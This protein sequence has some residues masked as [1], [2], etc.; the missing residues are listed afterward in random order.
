MWVQFSYLKELQRIIIV[1]NKILKL[2][3]IIYFIMALPLALS[4]C[5]ALS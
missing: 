2:T 4:I 5:S 1:S 3:E